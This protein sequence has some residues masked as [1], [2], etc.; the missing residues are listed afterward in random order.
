MQV[1]VFG[2]GEAGRQK[3]YDA[4]F[5][6]C[7]HAFLQQSSQWASVIADLGP[8]Q[9]L[10][11]LA[12]EAGRD[13]GGLPL[14]VFE[15]PSGPILTSVPQAGPLGGVFCRTDADRD[16]VYAAILAAADAEAR[17]R[18]CLAM[19]MI[20]NPV[21]PDIDLYRQ[22]LAPNLVFENFTQLVL[23]DRA[24]RDGRLVV[25]NNKKGNPAATI[26]KAM[27]GDF[28]I[29]LCRDRGEFDA[30]YG[31]HAR[32]AAEI[33]TSPLHRQLVERIWAELG[34][35]GQ[36]FLLLV[37][38]GDRIAA[39]CLFIHHAEVC[40]VFAISM[41]SQFADLAPNYL[42]IEASLLEMARRGLKIM[43]WQSSPRR[44]D[45]V[46]KFKRQWGSVEHLYY[47]VTRTYRPDHEIL[48]LGREGCKAGYPGHYVVPFDVFDTGT[49]A[50]EFAKG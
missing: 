4:L 49:V 28:T 14:Y 47:F 32:R 33:G 26:K 23:L 10:F 9:V 31:I 42:A 15:G 35:R 24:V 38:S 46:Y 6:S 34:Q 25:P 5:A 36:S 7:G 11:F 43:N 2:W 20:T 1:D 19:T 37:K 27:T 29:S 13:L 3:R 48:A 44:R 41:D 40:D 50:G 16:A 21:Q 45:G 22:H 39:G 18:A 12:H 8:D 30:W 17:A